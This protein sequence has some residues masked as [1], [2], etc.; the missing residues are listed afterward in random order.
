M[1]LR[2]LLLVHALLTFAAGLVLIFL[3]GLIPGTVSIQLTKDQYLLCYFLGAAEIALAYLSFLSRKL[4]DVR[5]LR[6][7]S[8]TFIVFHGLTGL[9]EF[10]AFIQGSD[11]KIVGNIVLRI[12]I[13]LLFIYYGRVRTKQSL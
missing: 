3:P 13:V 12:I 2:R 5:S 4:I 11:S 1:N 10:F 6:L 7:V 8:A 9:L